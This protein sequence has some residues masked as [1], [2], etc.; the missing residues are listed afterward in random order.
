MRHGVCCRPPILHRD[1]KAFRL[2]A[3]PEGRVSTDQL[4]SVSS[5]VY[6]SV[7]KKPILKPKAIR[8]IEVARLFVKGEGGLG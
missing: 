4:M 8:Y 1:L 3:M 6:Q 2:D 7:V 5:F